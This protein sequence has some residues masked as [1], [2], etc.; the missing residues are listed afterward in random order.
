M[1]TETILDM[2]GVGLRAA[3]AA[4]QRRRPT[5]SGP[6]TRADQIMRRVVL[7]AAEKA[8]SRVAP[9]AARPQGPLKRALPSDDGAV[10][11]PHI[12]FFP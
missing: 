9:V 10:G 4:L 2:V 6:D 1:K 3:D 8:L 11:A 12:L 5:S 7:P